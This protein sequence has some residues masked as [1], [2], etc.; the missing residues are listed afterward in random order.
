MSKEVIKT[1]PFSKDN[2]ILALAAI[3]VMIALAAAA[4]VVVRLRS[5]DFKV[6]VQYLVNDGG[7]VSLASWYSLY[8]LAVFVV[9]GTGV[10]LWLA[11]RLYTHRPIFARGV[12]L[13]QAVVGVVSFLTLNA[14]LGLVSQL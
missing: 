6:P 12:L 1:T 4:S 13:T 3:N 7:E 2:S 11:Y 8:S 10:A 14:L 5:H 9:F